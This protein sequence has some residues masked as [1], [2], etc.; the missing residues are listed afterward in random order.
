MEEY[1]EREF[2]RLI[3]GYKKEPQYVARAFVAYLDLKR[4]E[5]LE[6][7]IDYLTFLEQISKLSELN[8]RAYRK[9]IKT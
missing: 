3:K 4:Q 9:A 5:L 6:Q 2:Q 1:N 8:S 7:K